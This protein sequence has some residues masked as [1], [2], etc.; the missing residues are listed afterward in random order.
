MLSQ[1]GKE[2]ARECLTRSGLTDSTDSLCEGSADL[3][4]ENFANP[5]F[6]SR[7]SSEE[8]TM[9]PKNPAKSNQGV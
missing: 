2:A 4:G 7:N 9:R 8:L 5:A 1:E 6:D 3:D